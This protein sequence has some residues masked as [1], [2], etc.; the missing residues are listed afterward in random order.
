VFFFVL[1][2]FGTSFKEF[3]FSLMVQNENPSVF[4]FCELVRNGNQSFFNLPRNGLEQN[5][6]VPSVFLLLQN[7]SER[8]SKLFIF[9]GRN[10]EPFLFRKADGILTD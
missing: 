10:S 6:E 7:G 9:P 8:N 2:W 3:F 5:Y 1:E 4:L